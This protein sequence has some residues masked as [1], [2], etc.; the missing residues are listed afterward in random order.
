M[1]VRLYEGKV[2][3]SYDS[4]VS[5]PKDPF[6]PYESSVADVNGHVGYYG[7]SHDYYYGI[8]NFDGKRLVIGPSRQ[9]PISEQEL[10]EFAFECDVPH[11]EVEDFVRGMKSLNP[12]TLMSM[13][14]MLCIVNHVLNNG[15]TLSLTDVTIMEHEQ[16]RL[17][18][19]IG[20]EDA[21]R[22]IETAEWENLPYPHN[23]SDVETF[24]LQAVSKGDVAGLK[25]FFEQAPAVRAG[26]IAQ[27]GLRQTKNL[28]IVTATLVSRAAIRGGMDAESALRLSDEYVRK[29]E[30]ADDVDAVTNLNYRLVLDY[31]ERVERLHY[32]DTSSRLVGEVNKYLRR[33]LSEPITVGKMA[34]SLCR[35]RSRLSTDFK[36]ETGE[37]LSE[38][39]LKQKVE[40][41]KRLL[42]Y[43]DK[44]SAEISLYLGFSSQSHFSRTFK[45]YVG[46]TPGEYR[47][48]A[49]KP[50]WG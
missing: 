12:M 47:S 31:A 48:V 3:L 13:L 46:L 41:G 14:Q 40:E 35:G 22:T 33:H 37:N 10:K 11:V 27:S 8:V 44:A 45:K 34:K 24:M 36:K 15:E 28:L 4:I 29:C 39:L 42:R 30:L 6:V 20:A 43:T 9:V 25:S 26:V 32:G 7:A 21:R 50:K 18:E 2:R 19:S 16:N 23:T 17:I 38:Y 49:R 5:L 1:P